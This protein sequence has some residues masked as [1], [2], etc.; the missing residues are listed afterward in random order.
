MSVHGVPGATIHPNAR[1][2][3]FAG[4]QV[5]V[6]RLVIA[7]ATPGR[8]G[9]GRSSMRA[10]TGFVPISSSELSVSGHAGRTQRPL[11]SAAPPPRAAASSPTH[12]GGKTAL[13]SWMQHSASAGS[14]RQIRHVLRMVEIAGSRSLREARLRRATCPVAQEAEAPRDHRSSLQIR[15][16]TS[17][18]WWSARIHFGP[19]WNAGGVGLRRLWLWA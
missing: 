6:Q 5:A 8:S 7:S 10:A 11:S 16:R 9:G 4:R 15:P 2:L 18:I 13:A 12:G 3:Q 17:C 1:C 19:Q 14:G